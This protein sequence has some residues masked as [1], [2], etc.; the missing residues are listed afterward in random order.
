MRAHVVS[1]KDGPPANGEVGMEG[2]QIDSAQALLHLLDVLP[3]DPDRSSIFSVLE[4][5]IDYARRQLIRR[6][7]VEMNRLVA[8]AC[9]EVAAAT[10]LTSQRFFSFTHPD[11]RESTC[12]GSRMEILRVDRVVGGERS[13]LCRVLRKAKLTALSLRP[14][15]IVPL[16]GHMES[17]HG[18]VEVG[19]AMPVTPSEPLSLMPGSTFLIPHPVATSLI[20]D[21]IY[22]GFT[23]RP[24]GRRSASS[25]R[26]VPG[27]SRS[28]SV[29][30]REG[31]L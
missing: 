4:G 17:S 11:C 31:E 14:F 27:R 7:E 3:R 10:G 29:H 18:L 13:C 30:G 20:C 6:L 23:L 19:Q 16:S 28:A 22:A 24:P 26:L 2:G 1:L 8:D 9:E 12:R 25:L 5:A 15:R 21:A